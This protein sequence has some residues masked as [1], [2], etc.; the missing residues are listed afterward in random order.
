MR[1]FLAK[2]RETKRHVAIWLYDRDDDL[3]HNPEKIGTPG[4]AAVSRA[5][6][7][8]SAKDAFSLLESIKDFS[9]ALELSLGKDLSSMSRFCIYQ[10]DQ[11]KSQLAKSAF[12]APSRRGLATECALIVP[13]R[14]N[15]PYHESAAKRAAQMYGINEGSDFE[16]KSKSCSFAV[17]EPFSDWVWAR[18]IIALSLCMLFECNVAGE[19]PTNVMQRCG[20]EKHVKGALSAS[21]EYSLPG[22][23]D[24]IIGADRWRLSID[25]ALE[26]GSEAYTAKRFVSGVCNKVLKEAGLHASWDF[27]G[28]LTT[29]TVQGHLF[30]LLLGFQGYK[31]G[32][33]ERCGLPFFSSDNSLKRFCSAAC[34]QS[35]YRNNEYV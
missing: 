18:N 17:V 21:F 11:F 20:F 34:Q 28:S 29:S 32:R 35:S 25:T 22:S 27:D 2:S 3:H 1:L 4:V 9:G 24:A 13:G 5:N 14:E 10:G 26:G 33:C 15:V 19:R 12:S 30:A 6:R 31:I 23:P 16:S 7:F 8:L